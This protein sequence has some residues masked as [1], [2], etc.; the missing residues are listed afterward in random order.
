MN[1]LVLQ[2]VIGIPEVKE[3][4][5]CEYVNNKNFEIF[6]LFFQI[7]FIK[8]LT[9]MREKMPSRIQ[10]NLNNGQVYKKVGFLVFFIIKDP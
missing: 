4:N 9:F 3:N 10:R 5:S 1:R 2:E 6:F 7:N 8:F